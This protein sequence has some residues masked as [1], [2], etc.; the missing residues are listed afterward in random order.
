MLNRRAT[1]GHERERITHAIVLDQKLGDCVFLLGRRQRRIANG[2]P[3]GVQIMAPRFR[4]DLC[5]AA[6][7][8]IE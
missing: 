5:L 1:S 6:A 3:M 8:A 7:A 2:L 4:E